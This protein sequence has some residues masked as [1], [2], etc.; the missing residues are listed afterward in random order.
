MVYQTQMNIE[1]LCFFFSIESDFIDVPTLP[2]CSEPIILP[3]LMN[4]ESH[5]IIETSHNNTSSEFIELDNEDE[6]SHNS[7]AIED[8]KT[9]IDDDKEP[10]LATDDEIKQFSV[11]QLV[12]RALWEKYSIRNIDFLGII[13]TASS[14]IN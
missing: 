7:T 8:I 9:F 14:R 12:R 5:D 6:S 3:E 1:N 11:S 10:A 2:K 4:D 13:G